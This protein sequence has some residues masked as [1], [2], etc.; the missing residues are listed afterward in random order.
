[1]IGIL[2]TALVVALAL[3]A[4]LAVG[5][6]FLISLG[7]DEAWTMIGV[8]VWLTAAPV[9][10]Y[11][12]SPQWTSGGL[13]TISH[14]LMEAAGLTK[15]WIQR[16]PSAL[17]LAG[18]LGLVWWKVSRASRNRFVGLLA[19]CPMIGVQDTAII[20]TTA[21]G[22]SLAFLIFL[23]ATLLW[24]SQ[25]LPDTSTVLASGVLF[26]LAVS[27]R[28]DLLLLVPAVLLMGLVQ[29]E[30]T[31]GIRLALP[32][33]EIVV[34]TL[35]VGIFT[36]NLAIHRAWAVAH[37]TWS[38]RDDFDTA[39]LSRSLFQSVL[40]YPQLL[41]KVLIATDAMPIALMI[42]ATLAPFL[43]GFRE[44]GEGSDQRLALHPRTLVFL[45]L[46]GWHAWLAWVLRAEPPH[47]RYL[48]P[49]L[50]SF[51]V[52]LGV[53]LAWLYGKAARSNRTLP[54]AACL[55]VALGA[56]AGAIGVTSRALVEGHQD[57]LAW[58]RSRSIGVYPYRRF[59]YQG[60]QVALAQ[61]VK[62]SIPKD[63]PVCV[64]EHAMWL[65]YL[66]DRPV[67]SI[68][69]PAVDIAVP[70]PV[71]LVLTPIQFFGP[72]KPDLYR[73]IEEHGSL[74]AQFGRNSIYLIKDGLPANRSLF[75]GWSYHHPHSA[76]W[77]NYQHVT[78]PSDVATEREHGPE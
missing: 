24:T 56:I 37:Y 72:I 5:C 10:D 39:G 65:R 15:V 23:A 14:L 58:E 68:R 64:F 17:A 43:I 36:V 42:A 25:E 35:T 16:L 33:R 22:T 60:D 59:Q 66:T 78:L 38:L 47:A 51:A 11:H 69:G 54:V 20:G 29:T 40:E 13:Y 41:D 34:A 2:K 48:W 19:I 26:G 57:C 18:A 76:P 32:V 55:L 63:E 50:E 49:S 73:W 4:A 74:E 6:V 75:E 21:V 8:R 62:N 67:K 27:T 53:A 7:A 3:W 9:R 45:L 30:P 12:S 52:V 77:T 46:F 71:H 61:Y 1:M 31:L 44:A 70:G 28:T